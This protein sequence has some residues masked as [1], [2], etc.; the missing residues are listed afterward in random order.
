MTLIGFSFL[1]DFSMFKALILF[2]YT[3]SLFASTDLNVGTQ[4]RTYPALGIE[5]YSNLGY[6]KL[7][8]GE[9]NKEK[10]FYGF[11]RGAIDAATSVVVNSITPRLEF[12]P[13]SFINFSFG[14]QFLNSSY[15]KFSFYNCKE[16]RCKG[17]LFKE[18]IE[19]KMALGYK[20]VILLGTV[21]T[22]Y[23]KYSKGNGEPVGEFRYATR[24]HNPKDYEYFSQYGALYKT[25]LGMIGFIS[26]YSHYAISHQSY[27]STFAVFSP[28]KGNETYAYGLGH[29]E[30]SEVKRGIIAVFKYNFELKESPKLF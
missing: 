6:S 8:W 26:E 13:I 21:R 14:K 16:T 27:K 19:G 4:L 15:D 12:Y 24:V 9:V 22:S 29:F 18:F 23:N 7:I 11:I 30:S 5:A 17:D 2:F 25:N 1:K 28:K 20:G 10:P 3:T